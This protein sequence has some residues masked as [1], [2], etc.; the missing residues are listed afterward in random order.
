MIWRLCEK[1]HVMNNYSHIPQK[2]R[3]GWGKPWHILTGYLKIKLW[4][5]TVPVLPE[6]WRQ[7]HFGSWFCCGGMHPGLKGIQHC[8]NQCFSAGVLVK[9]MLPTAFVNAS[10]SF[11]SYLLLL[12]VKCCKISCNFWLDL[13]LLVLFRRTRRPAVTFQQPNCRFYAVI[14]NFF[15]II[16]WYFGNDLLINLC[17]KQFSDKLNFTDTP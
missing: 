1:I 11:P 2:F 13:G 16:Y 3:I 15:K 4:D 5:T 6:T 7:T 12:F 14:F 10:A 17:L 8:R 9:A